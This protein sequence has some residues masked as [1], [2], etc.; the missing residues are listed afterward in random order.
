MSIR[1]QP[2]FTDA[3]WVARTTRPFGN[4]P[5]TMASRLSRRTLIFRNEVCC[6]VTHPRS[7]GC[8]RRTVPVLKSKVSCARLS[9]SLRASSSKTRSPVWSW[10]SGAK[11]PRSLARLVF[12]LS[13]RV[14]PSYYRAR[15]YD[16]NVGRFISE[17]PI[18]F[19]GGE[20]FYLYTG[21]SPL[22]LTDPF[23][24]Y[25]LPPGVP[26]PS[27]ALDKLLKCLDGKV[28]PVRSRQRPTEYTR[29][30]AIR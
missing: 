12:R 27:P 15:Y 8:V 26:P 29:I 1:V 19:D 28:G 22:G 4:M 18:R 17:D 14:V 24:L 5:K 23:G 10:E 7:S 3:D 21:D 6:A 2:M 30:R 16:S 20:N 9:R 13:E 11:P 25:I